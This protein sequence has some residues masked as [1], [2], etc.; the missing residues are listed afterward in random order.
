MF[1][2]LLSCVMSLAPPA[3]AEEPLDPPAAPAFAPPNLPFPTLGG[4]Q[5]W[6][7]VTHRAGWRIQRHVLTGH[8]RLLDDWDLRRAWGDRATCETAL[9][10]EVAARDLPRPAGETVVLLH[11]MIRSGK[12]FAQLAADL[13]AAGFATVAVDYP[14]TRQSLRASAAML[15][16]VTDRLIRDQ[17]PADPVT[18]HFVCHSAGGL[19]LRAWTQRQEDAA[20]IGRTV[21]LGVPNGGASMADAVREIPLVGDSLDLLWGAAAAEL[22]RGAT[23]TLRSLPAPRGTFGTVAGCRGVEGGYNPLIEGDDDGTV[24]VSETHLPGEAE[25]LSVRGAG[26]SFLMMNAQIRAATARFLQS[27]TFHPPAAP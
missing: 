15:D 11:G 14:S 5:F 6:G 17:D 10:A 12:C 21:M 16:E 26:H 4:M 20:P 19:V 3:P 1:V 18:L 8:H 27:G 2:P 7:D 23:E 25:H 9:A 22:S 24:A 13:R